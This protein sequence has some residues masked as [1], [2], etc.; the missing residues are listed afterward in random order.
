MKAV[1]YS[2]ISTDQQS[3]SS[4]EDQERVCG[5]YCAREGLKV[6]ARFVDR[7]ISGAALGNRPGVL[8]MLEA[9]IAGTF[10]VLLV[11]D[12]TRLSRS[13]GDMSKVIDRLT[14]RGIRVIGVQDGFDSSRKGHKLQAGM[15]GIIGE[16]FRD[17][18]GERTYA[19]LESRALQGRP[20]G[21]KRYG[22][23][24]GE[25]DV[26][27][28]IFTWYADGLSPAWISAELN[29]LG[30]P[31]PGASWSRSTRR[32]GGWHPSAIAGHP[33]RGVG[34]LNNERYIGRTIWNRSRWQKDPDT[35]RRIRVDRPKSQWITTTNEAERIVPDE[36]W[37]QVK[38]RQGL[39]TREVGE[40]ISRALKGS[41]GRPNRYL[42][43]GLIRCECCGSTFIMTNA[44]AYGC[45]GY[46]N[47]RACQN[48]IRV[49]RDVLEDRLLSG[50]REQLLSEA[51]INRF[52]AGIRHRLTR[53]PTDPA[54]A[55]RR[56]LQA[57]IDRACYEIRQG[58]VSPSLRRDLQ[59]AEAELAALPP[60]ETAVIQADDV[61]RL[62]PE[63][64][65][66]YRRMVADLG[67]APVDPE[68]ARA[69]L[70]KLLGTILVEPRE[71]HLVAKLGLALGQ[72]QEAVFNGGSG[73]RI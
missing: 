22:Y 3:E 65:K 69:E 53:K 36:L 34:I 7:G 42:F 8:A 6:V 71:G 41:G 63:A 55:R 39:R 12:L 20:A 60:P 35:G 17:M 37:H 13:Q 66:R 47:G 72:P 57:E 61:L 18:I 73:G 21:G 40:R 44:R 64:V 16:S 11:M 67:N 1:I 5:T 4:I 26:V 2:R 25:A 70:R 23:G 28:R 68:R 62:L 46:V 38:R 19:A 31:S 33:Q 27:V 56:Q 30:V 51:S 54:A 32:R 10:D 48:N 59:A 49:R 50:I 29:R 24:P 45:S 9:A 14:V 43:S 52:K 58:L 15:A